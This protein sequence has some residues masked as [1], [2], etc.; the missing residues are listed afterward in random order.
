MIVDLVAVKVCG[1][2]SLRT[3]EDINK[4]EVMQRSVQGSHYFKEKQNYVLVE[5]N[6]LFFYI[7]CTFMVKVI[8]F[9]LV[10]SYVSVPGAQ[11]CGFQSKMCH[12]LRA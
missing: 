2:H 12:K 11:H 5:Y 8:K 7:C 10:V 4:V 1:K 9:I 3:E 6:W